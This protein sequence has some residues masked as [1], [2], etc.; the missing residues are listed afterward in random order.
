MT[1][2]AGL[3]PYGISAVCLHEGC[4]LTVMTPQA[5]LRINRVQEIH[6][7]GAVG[8]MAYLAPFGLQRFVH[9]LLLEGLLLMALIAEIVARGLQQ[10]IGIARMR[11]VTER[12]LPRLQRRV[13]IGLGHADL[14]FA[15]T[16]IAD[17]VADLLEHELGHDPVTKMAALAFLF[18]RHLVDMFHRKILLLELGMAVQTILFRE[19]LSFELGAA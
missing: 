15:M 2:G 3:G 1:L 8:N 9:D 14:L 5:Q 6:L 12:T 10:M 18:L 11:I 4:L 7:I 13:D 16:S 19:R 17:L